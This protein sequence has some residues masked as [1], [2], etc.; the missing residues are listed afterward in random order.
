VY[1]ITWKKDGTTDTFDSISAVKTMVDAVTDDPWEAGT[2][3][4]KDFG[5]DSWLFGT[6]TSYDEAQQT[7]TVKWEDDTTA[8]FSW[9]SEEL[10]LLVV[11]ADNY[12]GYDVGTKVLKQFDD[13]LYTGTISSFEVSIVERK[14][15]RSMRYDVML[16]RR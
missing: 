4:Y 3:I 12:D 8:T 15:G 1:T 11:N 7:Y 10:D 9:D 6:V 16:P 5:E 2:I 13:G 14:E